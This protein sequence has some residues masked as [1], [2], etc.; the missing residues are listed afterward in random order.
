MQRL[1]QFGDRFSV[2]TTFA[3]IIS[4]L[5]TLGLGLTILG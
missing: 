2:A 3:L 5:V 1:D 4:T